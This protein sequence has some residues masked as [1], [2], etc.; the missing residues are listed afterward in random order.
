MT[1]WLFAFTMDYLV[2]DL[3]SAERQETKLLVWCSNVLLESQQMSIPVLMEGWTC[4]HFLV[5]LYQ[6]S[7]QLIS[8]METCSIHIPGSEACGFFGKQLLD[9]SPTHLM[10]FSP[11][12]SILGSLYFGGWVCTVNYHDLCNLQRMGVILH[13]ACILWWLMGYLRQLRPM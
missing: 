7:C 5:I 8:E 11:H 3:H 4:W 1:S 13:T 9:S 2:I 12:S 10:F 6:V